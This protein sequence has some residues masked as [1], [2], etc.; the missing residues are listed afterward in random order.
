MILEHFPVDIRNRTGPFGNIWRTLQFVGRLSYRCG[1]RDYLMVYLS[2]NFKATPML[3]AVEQGNYAVIKVL[4]EHGAD[5]NAKNQI[6]FTPLSRA[7]ELGCPL[8][9]RLLE[10]KHG[11]GR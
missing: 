10:R 1:S 9:V 2:L 4:L 8:I 5:P 7:R 11:A 3:E 6:G